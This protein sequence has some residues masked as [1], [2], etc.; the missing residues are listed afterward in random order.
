MRS[1]CAR[2]S[3]VG[4]NYSLFNMIDQLTKSYVRLKSNIITNRNPIF[5]FYLYDEF[6]AGQ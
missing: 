5:L 3:H 6:G 4:F 1:T 2:Y